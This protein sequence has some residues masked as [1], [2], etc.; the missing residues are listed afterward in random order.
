M[1]ANADEV[2]HAVG[3]SLRAVLADRSSIIGASGTVDGAGLGLHVEDKV[4]C[5]GG[6]GV[7]CGA[8]DAVVDA[9]LASGLANRQVEAFGA[10]AQV[11]GVQDE[12]VNASGAH[13]EEVQA[14][15]AAELTTSAEEVAS[16]LVDDLASWARTRSVTVLGGAHSAGRALGSGD[17]ELAACAAR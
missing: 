4:L 3:A 13:I 14:G 17:A 5:A 10:H 2:V 11:V 6:A 7:G 1:T 16:G 9:P 15:G 12:P 8:D